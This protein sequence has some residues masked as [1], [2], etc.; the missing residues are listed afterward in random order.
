M[1]FLFSPYGRTTRL[2]F[3]VFVVIYIA[4]SFGS[5]EFDRMAGLYNAELGIGLFA[6]IVGLFFVWPSIAVPVRRFHD[7]GMTG[8]WV[9]WFALI[10]TAAAIGAII[11]GVFAGLEIEALT[12]VDE[13]ATLQD[14]PVILWVAMIAFAIPYIVQIVLLG[15]LRGEQK[16]NRFDVGSG[17][18]NAH[19]ENETP[20]W[21]N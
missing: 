7:L 17:V 12:A 8:W 16:E 14:M 4:S 11:I 18:S 21:A 20:P 6:T 3:W 10:S 13:I 9:L 1:R 15:F 19:E 2:W 5:I